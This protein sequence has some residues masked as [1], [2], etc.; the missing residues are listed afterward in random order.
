MAL[1]ALMIDPLTAAVCSLHEIKAMFFE[2]YTA[3]KEYIA[4]LK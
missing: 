3:E 1:H 2:L 4:E